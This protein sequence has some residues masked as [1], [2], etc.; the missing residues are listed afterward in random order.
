MLADRKTSAQAAGVTSERSVRA[1]V[2]GTGD[3]IRSNKGPHAMAP[4]HSED[5]D[6]P[7][8]DD[9]DK[10]AARAQAEAWSRLPG[11]WRSDLEAE[12]KAELILGGRTSGREVASGRTTR[13]AGV[14]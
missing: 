13:E 1:W 6:D 11:R 14:R 5:P 9:L 3:R 7:R 8:P 2:G 12:E 10:A 4:R